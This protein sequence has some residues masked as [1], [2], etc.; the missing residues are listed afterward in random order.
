MKGRF[1]AGDQTLGGLATVLAAQALSLPEVALARVWLIGPG[2]SCVTCPLAAEC[3]ERA[4]CLHLVASAG[5][6]SKTDGEFR[7]FPLGARG[8]GEVPRRL[9]PL[10]LPSRADLRTI[11]DPRWL[12]LHRIASFGAWPIRDAGQVFGV[13]AVF[14]RGELL[15]SDARAFAALARL[16]GAACAVI[17]A[18][19]APAPRPLRSMADL[20]RDAI[21]DVLRATG[22]KVSG[23]GGAA[24]IL[25]MKSTTLESRIRKL[26]VRKPPRRRPLQT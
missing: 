19:D 21:L 15:A 8:V 18:D 10:V 17:A 2:D 3:P 24:E 1:P 12:A 5:L 13:L 9:E 14:S 22:G 7:R 16:A 11:A 25:R 4:S 23:R 6:T 26:G 20:Q